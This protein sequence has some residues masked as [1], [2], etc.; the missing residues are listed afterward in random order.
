MDN[1]Q[2]IISN[3]LNQVADAFSEFVSR[4]LKAE[5]NDVFQFSKL[6]DVIVERIKHGEQNNLGAPTAVRIEIN[7]PKK[8]APKNDAPYKVLLSLYYKQG[9]SIKQHSSEYSLKQIAN[10]PPSVAK[11]IEANGG[12]KITFDCND[13]KE[14]QDNREL[15]ISTTDEDI[16][17]LIYKHIS[18][19]ESAT[20]NITDY[21]LYYRVKI[22]KK[23]DN[24]DVCTD[25]FLTSK[26]IGLE[27]D[28]AEKLSSNHEV[29]LVVKP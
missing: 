5:D 7:A 12:E 22:F 13:I 19:S 10:I 21:V 26:I 3:A 15:P 24:A 14:F 4:I 1:N 18:K 27:K 16:S 28:T 23:K 9:E 25:V 29:N 17:T 6:R 11:S 20:V 2:N 8:D